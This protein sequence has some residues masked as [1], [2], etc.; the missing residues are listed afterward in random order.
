MKKIIC[1]C[2]LSLPL[3]VKSQNVGIG[4]P[5]PKA[6][7]HVIDSSVVFSGMSGIPG[8]QGN[9]PVSGPGKRMMWYSD[10][11]AFR[12]GMVDSDKWDKNKTGD[13]SFAGGYETEASGFASTSFGNGSR[14]LGVYSFATGN[15]TKAGGALSFA[16]G[17]GTNARSYISTVVGSYND[18]IITSSPGSWQN[19]D[20]IFI[21]GNGFDEANRRNAMIVLKNGKT[22]IGTNS[23]KARLHVADSSVV[24]SATGFVPDNQGTPPVSGSGRRMMWYPDKAAF[25]VGFVSGVQWDKDYIGDFSFA[26][27][28]NSRASGASSNAMGYAS[29]ASGAYSNAWGYAS[30]ASGGASTACGQFTNASGIS[31]TA[32]GDG[33]EASGDLSTSMGYFTDA[34]PYLSLA[35][36]RFN[37][38]IIGSSK[39]SWILNDPLFMIGNGSSH[40]SRK[41]A[42]V[43]LKNGNTGI[44][45]STPATSLH[46]KHSSDNAGGLTL[47]NTV[48]GNKWR[49][50]S[51]F[52]DDNLTFFN[53]AN[54]EIA[55]IDDAT[56]V[57]S[58]L[59]DSRFKKNIEIMQPVLSSVLQLRP[60]HYHFNWQDNYE[61]K[62]PGL[63]A[64][65]AIA[66]FPELVSYNK[67]KDLYKMNY[68]GFSVIAIKA[69]QEQQVLIEQQQKQ[70][71]ELIKEIQ[72]IRRRQ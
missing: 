24:F 18:S 60:K 51:A 67:E 1:L 37:D 61:V 53:N 48:D 64:Q 69:I 14:A 49:L 35:I 71:D 66:L 65:E 33:T 26:A 22:G 21:I 41:N 58:A 38:T 9:P 2:I 30:V 45:T 15:N 20:P 10:K 19:S 39:D 3:I 56:G 16:S 52:G 25:R 4:T 27:G 68:A 43:V 32:L 50:Y 12:A 42:M 8:S 7:L 47:E 54:T 36:G 63:L 72:F 13:L 17:N 55:D 28:H 6:R 46:I 57:F 29:E 70:I 59:S 44:G 5:N 34:R 31:S 40:V 62:Q 23:P 11:A